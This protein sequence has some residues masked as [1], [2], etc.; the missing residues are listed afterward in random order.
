[1]TALMISCI[2]VGGTGVFFAL[3]S[4][5]FFTHEK[6]VVKRCSAKTMGNV[7]DYKR[8]FGSSETTIAPVAEFYVDGIQYTAYRHYRG[9]VASKKVTSA[10][11]PE[12]LTSSFYISDNDWFHKFQNGPVADYGMQ[13]RKKWPLGSELPVVY[14][15]NKPEQAYVEK[16][17]VKTKI[18]GIVLLSVGAVIALIAGLMFLILG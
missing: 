7:I 14:N 9:V 5:L 3:L 8:S 17:V 15:P 16:V 13:A 2:A 4:I 12:T 1:M 10:D 18:A 11:K 6:R